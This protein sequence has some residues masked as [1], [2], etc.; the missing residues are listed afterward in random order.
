[1]VGGL[2]RRYEL[3]EAAS[4]VDGLVGSEGA[5]L[6]CSFWLVNALYLIGH[7]DEARA[8]FEKLLSLRNDV[9]LLSEEYDT[10]YSRLVGNTPQAF[11]HVPLIQAA[12]NLAA[13]SPSHCRRPAGRARG[14]TGHGHR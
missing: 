10:R 8:L 9:G 4:D 14:G 1:M 13:H 7:E 11:S 6:A 12:A 5:F 3:V 2:L